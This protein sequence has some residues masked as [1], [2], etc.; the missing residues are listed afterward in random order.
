MLEAPQV[1]WAPAWLLIKLNIDAAGSRRLC[2]SNKL[3][4][5]KASLVGAWTLLVAPG[6][7]TNS[8]KLH[9]ST[10]NQGIATSTKGITTRSK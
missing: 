5:A 3:L 4:V 6:L 9:E 2:Y 7:T 10:S 8:K 1:K